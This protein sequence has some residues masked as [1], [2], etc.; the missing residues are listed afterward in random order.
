VCL[1]LLIID[2]HILLRTEVAVFMHTLKVEKGWLSHPVH[3]ATVCTL[4]EYHP[5]FCALSPSLYPSIPLPSLT[6]SPS[7]RPSTPP[8][9]SLPHFV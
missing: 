3:G 8:L 9:L 6:S 2:I 4:T 1:E 5:I 7:L